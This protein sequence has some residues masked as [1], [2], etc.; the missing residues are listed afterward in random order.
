[1]SAS[2]RSSQRLAAALS[3]AAP[4][5]AAA[6]GALALAPAPAF[7]Q[8]ATVQAQSL[9]DQGRALL[10][11]GQIAEACA[12]FEASQKL[13]PVVTTLLNL[14]A[15]REQNDQLATAWG[16]FVEA[17]RMATAAGNGKLAAVATRHAARIKP[18]LSQLRIAMAE[19][20]A[21]GLELRRG[22]EKVPAATWGF[23]LPVDGGTYTFTARAPGYRSWTATLT[24]KPSSE[25][26]TLQVPALTKLR[27]GEADVPLVAKPEAPARPIRPGPPSSGDAPPKKPPLAARPDAPAEPARPGAPAEPAT[28]ATEPEPLKLGAAA[29][30]APPRRS[31]LLPLSFGAGAVVLGGVAVGL[32]LYGNTAYDKAEA[33]TLQSVRDDWYDTANTRRAFA[34]GA[35]ALAAGSAGAAIY[36]YVRGGP[37]SAPEA[38]A[39]AVTVT[40]TP[41]LT[42]VLVRGGW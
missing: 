30:A 36:F 12:A 33:A 2:R 19:P 25:N 41:A 10:E 18:T 42:G 6:L 16:H 7:A 3:L 37:R 31:R 32:H 15:C 14:A 5:A 29:P 38:S 21:P 1:M 40:A 35:A 22:R 26:R 39:T 20:R 11:K 27:D 24:V 9:F 23:A 34:L 8:S 13:E 28:A 17:N 4:A